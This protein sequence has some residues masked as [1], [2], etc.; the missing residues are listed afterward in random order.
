MFNWYIFSFASA[1]LSAAA[2]ISQKKILL[3]ESAIGFSTL[4]A[5]FN[6]A[7]AI[8]FFFFV[9]YSLLTISGILVLLLK[10]TLGA[11]AFLL[12]MLGIKKLEISKALPLLVLTPG[13]VAIFAFIFLGEE[14]TKFEILGVILLI[15]GTY[16]LS[17]KEKQSLKEP[18]KKAFNKK[19]HF[20]IIG[21]LIIFTITSILDKAVLNNFKVPLNAFMGLQHLF[22]AI[23]FMILIFIS[24]KQLELKSAIKKSWAWIMLIAFFTIAYRYTH[25]LAI[26]QV[27]VALALSIK[28]LSVFIAVVIGGTIFKEKRLFLKIIATALMIFGAI[29][30]INN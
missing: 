23:I 13:I 14:L 17:L 1:I 25:L 27:P 16:I 21:A 10:S 8:P 26:K 30:I 7:L 24:K 6:L 15:A 9:N 5:L 19:G 18:F 11:V 2:A 28:R 3:K 4:V 12:V 20:Y 22:F 29:L